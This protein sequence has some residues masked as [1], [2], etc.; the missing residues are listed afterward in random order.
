MA[1]KASKKIPEDIDY[2]AIGT[3]SMES[4]EKLSRVRP[5]DIAQVRSKAA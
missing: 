1:A 3:L 4:R 5:A 2:M